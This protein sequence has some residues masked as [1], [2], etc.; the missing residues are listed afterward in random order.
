MCHTLSSEVGLSVPA[1]GIIW[2]KRKMKG[3]LCAIEAKGKRGMEIARSRGE[4]RREREVAERDQEGEPTPLLSEHPLPADKSSR[5]LI[6]LPSISSFHVSTYSSSLS[7]PLV[8][9]ALSTSLT[10]SLSLFRFLVSSS[11]YIRSRATLQKIF[12]SSY[13]LL[14]PHRVVG[15]SSM[16]GWGGTG[17]VFALPTLSR[18]LLEL[19]EIILATKCPLPVGMRER[20]LNYELN[21]NFLHVL[22]I[23]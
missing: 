23:P 18:E 3:E 11:M 16:R 14:H 8:R 10:R 19:L 15:G 5:P 4:G 20:E 7:L 12:P 6:G 17:C 9:S 1:S 21:S 13:S 2:T 22:W